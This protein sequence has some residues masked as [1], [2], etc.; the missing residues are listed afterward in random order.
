MK[1]RVA[2][3]YIDV[4]CDENVIEY[5]PNLRPFVVAKEGADTARIENEIKTMPDYFAESGPACFYTR[6]GLF[7][8]KDFALVNR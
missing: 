6:F 1:L 5:L 7:K 4:A 2:D 3:F 8:V